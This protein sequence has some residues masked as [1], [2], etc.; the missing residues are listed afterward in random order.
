MNKESKEEACSILATEYAEI[1]KASGFDHKDVFNKYM[2]RCMTRDEEIVAQQAMR[3]A[4]QV[5]KKNPEISWVQE[6]YKERE[7]R[8][9]V[10]VEYKKVVAKVKKKETNIDYLTS[11]AVDGMGFL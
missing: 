3:E 4:Y 11:Y 1:A 6:W 8:K 10:E 5:I 2:N 7:A 9:K